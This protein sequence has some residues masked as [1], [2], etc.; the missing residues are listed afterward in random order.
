V[1]NLHLKLFISL[2][3]LFAHSEKVFSM[4]GSVPS[5]YPNTFVMGMVSNYFPDVNNEYG[6]GVNAQVY[7]LNTWEGPVGGTSFDMSYRYL[8]G[9]YYSGGTTGGNGWSNSPLGVGYVLKHHADLCKQYNYDPVFIYYQ[10]GNEV[11]NEGGTSPNDA[12]G[13]GLYYQDWTYTMYLI[14]QWI[15]ANTTGTYTPVVTVDLEPDFSGSVEQSN[16]YAGFGPTLFAMNVASCT[17]P[18]PALAAPG[19]PAWIS[20]AGYANNFQGYC[21]AV[22]HIK[23]QVVSPANNSRVHIAFHISSWATNGNPAANTGY[24]YPLA[25]VAAHAQTISSFVTA[26]QPAT[27]SK[28]DLFFNDPSGYDGHNPVVGGPPNV[29]DWGVGGVV[30]IADQYAYFLNQI[31]TLTNLRGILWQMPLGN[32]KMSDVNG[33]YKD[34]RPE[35]FL[36]DSP[37]NDQGYAHNICQYMASGIIGILWGAGSITSSTSVED[38]LYSSWG[39]DGTA[40]GGSGSWTV[41]AVIDND[42]GFMRSHAANAHLWAAACGNTATPTSTATNTATN[43]VTNTATNTATATLSSTFTRTPTSTMTFTAT[44]TAT[45][46]LSSTSTNTAAN[47]AS[48]TSTMTYTASATATLSSTPTNSSTYSSTSTGT[49]S[50]TQTATFTVTSTYTWSPTN[51]PVI[52]FTNTGT[53]TS[54]LS[55]TPTATGTFSFT[56][57]AS[58]TLTETPVFTATLTPTETPVLT[59]TASMTLTPTFSN[60][61]TWTFTSL[62]STFTFTPTASWTFTPTPVSTNTPTLTATKTSTFTPAA[63][64]TATNTPLPYEFFISKNVFTSN[65][66]VSISVSINQYPGIYDLTIY[67]SAGENIKNLDHQQLTAAFSKIYAWDGRNK[68]GDKCASGTYVVYL[69][70]PFTRKLGRVLLIKTYK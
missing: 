29:Y 52:V 36:A 49:A 7:T 61:P 33:H 20:L 58:F 27:G 66:P 67:N 17:V 64:S 69:T 41:P 12:V 54:T 3:L 11:L 59:N 42:G 39:E 25:T 16:L 9:G 1:K 68:F 44:P 43:T 31:S 50:A 10:I 5:G 19:C 4:G 60:T 23:D 8:N 32:S 65:S 26:C 55:D 37:L 30:G 70:E 24:P 38:M 40:N 48:S 62:N 18:S 63:T 51:T 57:T 28:F 13:M 34:E 6:Y 47:T 45:F 2:F 15:T 46:T 22:L 14:D 53:A 35:Y 56:S 21:A